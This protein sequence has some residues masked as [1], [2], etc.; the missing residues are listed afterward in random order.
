MSTPVCAI[1]SRSWTFW[2][3]APP[4][5]RAFG[6]LLLMTSCSI[7]SSY[8]ERSPIHVGAMYGRHIRLESSLCQVGIESF[9]QLA[10]SPLKNGTYVLVSASHFF[11]SSKYLMLSRRI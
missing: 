5:M 8:D 1:F 2:I 9:T 11:S 3:L 4:I 6:S 10:M 7:L